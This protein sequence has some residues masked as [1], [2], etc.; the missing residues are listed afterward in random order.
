MTNEE[1]YEDRINSI[2]KNYT[3]RQLAHALIMANNRQA[4][5]AKELDYNNTHRIKALEEIGLTHKI[6][7]RGFHVISSDNFHY[8]HTNLSCAMERIGYLLE[9]K[10]DSRY[11]AMCEEMAE[12]L[13]YFSRLE[14][15]SDVGGIFQIKTD[16]IIYAKNILT[17]WNAMKGEK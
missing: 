2:L 11:K 16:N 6:D 3:K 13:E 8:A 15:Y 4:L 5:E 17:K 12:C 14:S 9:K 7:D 10:Q 1:A